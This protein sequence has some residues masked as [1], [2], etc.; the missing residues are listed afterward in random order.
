LRPRPAFLPA[1]VQRELALALV[2]RELAL[3]LAQRELA[4]ALAQRE[5]A[6]ALVQRELALALAQR[7]P[8][9]ALVQRELALALVQRE[10]AL[11]LVQRELALAL[12]EPQ[13]VRVQ[14][15]LALES[16]RRL[17]V[18]PQQ[19]RLEDS[20][21]LPPRAAVAPIR[22]SRRGARPWCRRHECRLGT[23]CT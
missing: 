2:Q 5:L 9:L 13:Q 22:R 15:V 18:E 4:L 19:R 21:M 17:S 1:L 14:Q 11:A 10:L 20:P 23:V 16:H 7:E 12:G 6:L 3:A 8:A